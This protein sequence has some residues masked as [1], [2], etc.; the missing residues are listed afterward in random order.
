M[1]L[2]W[3]SRCYYVLALSMSSDQTTLAGDARIF[4]MQSVN[5]AVCDSELYRCCFLRPLWQLP[6]TVTR[7]C[8]FTL[9]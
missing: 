6:N 9:L 3:H 5:P 4:A 7:A 8:Y 1:L 2:P